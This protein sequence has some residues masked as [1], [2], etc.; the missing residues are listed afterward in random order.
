LKIRAAIVSVVAVVSSLGL[1][2]PSAQAAGQV[3]Y[4]VQ[5]NAQGQS[6]VSQ[7]G[8]QDLPV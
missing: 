7:S 3:C 8:C 1:L 6:V 5:V 4:D 2:A